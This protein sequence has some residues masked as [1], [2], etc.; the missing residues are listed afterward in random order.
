MACKA[1]TKEMLAMSL[2]I[3]KAH[4]QELLDTSGGKVGDDENYDDKVDDDDVSQAD[5]V[6]PDNDGDL[7][8]NAGCCLPQ[9]YRIAKTFPFCCRKCSGADGP[10]GRLCTTH[11]AQA[12]R[13]SH[14]PIPPVEPPPAH[15][16]PQHME[17]ST[18]WWHGP[19]SSSSTSRLVRTTTQTEVLIKEFGKD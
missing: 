3:L 17:H 19:R 7:C 13:R 14:K 6:G 1:K 8:A 4:I 2:P 12:P 18:R 16:V 15:L 11:W 10:H 9:N 5:V